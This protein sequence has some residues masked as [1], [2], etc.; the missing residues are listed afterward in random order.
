V[1]FSFLIR[2]CFLTELVTAEASHQN[3]KRGVHA[4]LPV[5]VL[6]PVQRSVDDIRAPREGSV[7]R[8]TCCENMTDF[9]NEMKL[10]GPSSS[11]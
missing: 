10:V 3:E 2:D 7:H 6:L 8:G 9:I 5:T 4:I 11:L 1:Y